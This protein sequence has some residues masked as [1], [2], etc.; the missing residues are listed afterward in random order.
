MEKHGD[1]R[2]EGKSHFIDYDE[3]GNAYFQSILDIEAIHKYYSVLYNKKRSS[4]KAPKITG[5]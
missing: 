4:K 2:L 1:E 5:P 3:D